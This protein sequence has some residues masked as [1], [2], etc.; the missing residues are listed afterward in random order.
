M[1]VHRRDRARLKL[2]AAAQIEIGLRQIP[3][4]P[5]VSVGTSRSPSSPPFR[6]S[7]PSNLE[8]PKEQI[9]V[10]SSCCSPFFNENPDQSSLQIPM[11]TGDP[12]EKTPGFKRRK[13]DLTVPLSLRFSVAGESLL[14][15]QTVGGVSIP[16]EGIDLELRLGGSAFG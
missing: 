1:N 16:V 14:Q 3:C 2:S 12:K 13:R 4:P 9:L 11:G 6:V 10:A 7:G 5:G 8:S 15:S